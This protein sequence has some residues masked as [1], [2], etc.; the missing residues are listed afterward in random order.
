MPAE[1]SGPAGNTGGEQDEAHLDVRV[2]ESERTAASSNS[3][4]ELST[5]STDLSTEPGFS[6][7]DA[8]S[9]R[10]AVSDP[11]ADAVRAALAR[12]RSAAIGRGERPGE[13]PRSGSAL[14]ARARERRDGANTR[15]GARPDARDP[16]PITSA[17]ARLVAER[18]W[19]QPVKVGGVL[20]RWD[21]VVGSD[22]AAH[23][24]P[25]SFEEGVLTVAADSSTWAAQ[26]KLLTPT[27]LRKLADEVGEGT[28]SRIVVRGPSAPSWKHGPRIAPGAVG[29][30][31]TYG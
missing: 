2:T 20:G 30:R 9:A 13:P 1:S 7:A 15:S 31:D 3:R 29:P 27:L 17:I 24:I 12:A 22:L 6:T 4:H 21:A 19:S 23:C 18:G 16:Q 10:E 14:A 11:G 26:L 5:Q 8:E 25:L 28:V